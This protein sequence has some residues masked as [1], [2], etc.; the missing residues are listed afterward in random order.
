[1]MTRP[2]SLGPPTG[3]VHSTGTPASS[4]CSSCTP[5]GSVTTTAKNGSWAAICSA[6]SERMSL[7]SDLGEHL[8]AHI[9]ERFV[10]RLERRQQH[11]LLQ[12]GALEGVEVL[13]DVRAAADETARLDP[14]GGDELPLLGL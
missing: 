7:L 3:T 10:L 14:L 1:M 12:T 11:D 6:S 8:A 5:S 4:S 2:S 13:D 9:G